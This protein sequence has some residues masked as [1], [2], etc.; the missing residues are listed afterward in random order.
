MHSTLHVCIHTACTYTYL[1][2]RRVCVCVSVCLWVCVCVSVCLCLCACVCVSV[3]LCLCLCAAPRFDIGALKAGAP[4]VYMVQPS[5]LALFF[6]VAVFA[7][8][9][10]GVV[11][12]VQDAMVGVVVTRIT[13][14]DCL[15]YA[16][17]VCCC[18]SVC[19]LC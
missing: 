18:M 11:I 15:A 7:F 5:S 16:C 3:C 8:E 1:H 17:V 12:P 4:P 2:V 13:S 10:I 6:G 14:V 19:V 9:G